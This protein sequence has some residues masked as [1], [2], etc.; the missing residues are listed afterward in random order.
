MRDRF[1]L[2]PH[3][4]PS[5][6]TDKL[7]PPPLYYSALHAVPDN[8][9]AAPHSILGLSPIIA[10]VQWST[11]VQGGSKFGV[12]SLFHNILDISPCGSRF[13]QDQPLSLSD[14]SLEINILEKRAKKTSEPS[15][16]K[17]AERQS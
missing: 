13:W 10:A 14:K 5:Q 11:T 7:Q 12:K 16:A 8:L 3:L 2:R 17:R 15:N 9:K 1:T 6:S 4:G